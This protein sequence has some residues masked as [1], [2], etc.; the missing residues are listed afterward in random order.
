MTTNS[1]V[2]TRNPADLRT[3][4]LLVV[5]LVGLDVAARLLPHMPNLTPVAASALFAGTVLHRRALAPLVPLLALL[6]SD[7]VL[8]FDGWRITLLTYAASTVPAFLPM[9]WQRLRAPGMFAPV[10]VA[11]S[12]IF[13]V[14]T[15]F[16]VWA[17]SAMYPPTLDGLLAC[18]IA[19]L[20][21][22]QHTIV[23][24][25]L[26]AVALFGGA[27]LVRKITARV[28]SNNSDAGQTSRLRPSV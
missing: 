14:V 27:W 18:Y 16:G 20:P 26:W 4:L 13:F 9:L 28:S 10:M 25:L 1:P 3:D 24:D 22:L 23:G 17:F 12:L 21:F 19:A 2:E 8:G 15:N 6:I 5:F 7:S 11:C